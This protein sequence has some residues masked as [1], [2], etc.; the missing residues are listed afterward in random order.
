LRE[1][2]PLSLLPGALSAIN[3]TRAYKS[4]YG[5]DTG[6]DIG[7]DMSCPYIIDHTLF[8]DQTI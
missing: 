4:A 3:K 1:E 6:H 5:H 7:H 2:N 8:D